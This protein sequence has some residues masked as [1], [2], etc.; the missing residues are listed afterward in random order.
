MTKIQLGWSMGGGGGN[1]NVS[2]IIKINIFGQDRTETIMGGFFWGG[3]VFLLFL[4]VGVVLS[5]YE[6]TLQFP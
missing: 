5:I 3:V 4:C 1:S 6:F 2:N